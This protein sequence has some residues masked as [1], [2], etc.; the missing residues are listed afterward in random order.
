MLRFK[1]NMV[2]NA[3]PSCQK[4]HQQVCPLC[5]DDVVQPQWVNVLVYSKEV[6]MGAVALSSA[7]GEHWRPVK[8]H[9]SGLLHCVYCASVRDSQTQVPNVRVA[10]ACCDIQL[11]MQVLFPEP[12]GRLGTSHPQPVGI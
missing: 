11:R 8:A 4:V 3:L 7:F 5:L 2:G 10:G 12:S 9:K 6:Q 1:R